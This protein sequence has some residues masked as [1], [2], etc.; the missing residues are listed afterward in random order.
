[1][2][3]KFKYRIALALRNNITDVVDAF[4]LAMFCIGVYAT[5]N[6]AWCRAEIWWCR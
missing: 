3:M 5:V 4:C 1:M 2:R 6:F